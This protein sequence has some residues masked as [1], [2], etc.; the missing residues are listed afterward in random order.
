[1]GTFMICH[2]NICGLRVV[3]FDYGEGYLCDWMFTKKNKEKGLPDIIYHLNAT[4][5]K[6]IPLSEVF[7][8]LR[9]FQNKMKNPQGASYQLRTVRRKKKIVRYYLICPAME[10]EAT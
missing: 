8:H 6:P 2:N 4:G 1:M 9:F 7:R 5:D 10:R 3:K